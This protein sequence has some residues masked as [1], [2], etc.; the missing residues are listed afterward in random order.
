VLGWPAVHVSDVDEA[1][2]RHSLDFC[3]SAEGRTLA[4]HCRR[5]AV[6]LVD[7]VHT[8]FLSGLG[9]PPGGAP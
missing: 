3:L 7:A 9:L 2:L 6:G 5:A 4:T 8:E 1:A